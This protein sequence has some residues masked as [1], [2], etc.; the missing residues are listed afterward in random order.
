MNYELTTTVFTDNVLTIQVTRFGV[1][2]LYCTSK[3][4]SLYKETKYRRP[5]QGRTA[6][7]SE[8]NY[9]FW[10]QQVLSLIRAVYLYI[11]ITVFL[12]IL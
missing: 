2:R 11:L 7:R 10:L 5:E 8:L 6:W 12:G 9:M 4:T 3:H 1:C